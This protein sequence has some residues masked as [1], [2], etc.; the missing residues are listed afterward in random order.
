MDGPFRVVKNL[1]VRLLRIS[2][3]NTL[4][5]LKYI[6][7]VIRIANRKAQMNVSI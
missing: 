4:I 2:L 1:N 7:S 6:F 3:I 5:N